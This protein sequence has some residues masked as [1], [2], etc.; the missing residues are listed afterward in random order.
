MGYHIDPVQEGN[1]CEHAVI[2]FAQLA[3]ATRWPWMCWWYRRKVRYFERERDRW[4]GL[5]WQRDRVM[6]GKA[7]S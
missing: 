5:A 1:G 7:A 6:E 2:V 3:K 4:Y